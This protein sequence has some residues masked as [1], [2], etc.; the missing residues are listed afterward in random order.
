MAR[1]LG[2]IRTSF[3]ASGRN[4][5]MIFYGENPETI[6]ILEEMDFQS[7]ELNLHA[8]WSQFNKYRAFIFTSLRDG[9]TN[10]ND[11]LAPILASVALVG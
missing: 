1:V 11:F 10:L 4:I 6:R 2:N 5:K 8:D 7:K 9:R 3:Q